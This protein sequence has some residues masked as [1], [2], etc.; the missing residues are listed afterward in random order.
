MLRWYV[1]LSSWNPSS[2]EF[3][4]ILLNLSEEEQTQKSILRFI[5]SEDKKRALVSRLLQRAAVRS[6]CNCPD[7]RILRTKGQ[8][9]FCMSDKPLYAPNFNFNVSH[10]VSSLLHRTCMGP[11]VRMTICCIAYNGQKR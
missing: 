2:W 10:E 11:A 8:K 5:R 4:S 9:P 7:V 6:I 1:N 3:E